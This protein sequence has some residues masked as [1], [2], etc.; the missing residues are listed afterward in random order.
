MLVCANKLGRKE[1]RYRALCSS[2]SL[3]ERNVSHALTTGTKNL[4]YVYSASTLHGRSDA[5]ED[6][7]IHFTRRERH[8]LRET[9]GYKVAPGMERA[10]SRLRRSGFQQT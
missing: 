3:V 1:R 10:H 9:K 4:V 6:F 7:E 2:E 5:R 8:L